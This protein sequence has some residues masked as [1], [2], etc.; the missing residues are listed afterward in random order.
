MADQLYYCQPGKPEIV[1]AM[2][3]GA[4]LKSLLSVTAFIK[5]TQLFIYDKSNIYF[6]ST[7]V[8]TCMYTQAIN[9]LRVPPIER[10]IYIYELVT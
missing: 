8:F 1:T 4:M 5:K 2:D 7:N 6:K 10:F 3:L 9:K